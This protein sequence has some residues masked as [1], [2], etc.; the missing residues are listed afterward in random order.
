MNLKNSF[1][2][3]VIT[4]L[5]Y[6]SI[7][8]LMPIDKLQFL[9]YGIL[10]LSVGLIIF[11]IE[12]DVI[13]YLYALSMFFGVAVF[14]RE[15]VS[16]DVSDLLFPLFCCINFPLL[17]QNVTKKYKNI[18]ISLFILIAILTLSIPFNFF[19]HP[20]LFS[21]AMPWYLY[22]AIQ[23]PGVVLILYHFLY[24]KKNRLWV[25]LSLLLVVSMIQIP[26]VFY[27]SIFNHTGNVI[28]AGVHGT[29]RY[30]HSL[31]A[32][33]FFTL[34]PLFIAVAIESKI[35]IHRIMGAVLTVFSFYVIVISGSR[36]VLLGLLVGGGLYV[37]S[38]IR[39]N[40][41]SIAVLLLTPLIGVFLYFFTPLKDIYHHTFQ[42]N[43]MGGIDVSSLS[44]LLIWKETLRTF[45]HSSLIEKCIGIGAGLYRTI[46]YEFVI[47]DGS[48][49]ASGAHNNYLHLLIEV[50]V[51]GLLAFFAHFACLGRFL[52]ALG[53][54]DLASK[55]FF[56]GMIG[57]LM[58][59]ITQETFW[60]QEA[61]GSF[62]VFY[63]T[64]FTVIVVRAEFSEK[65]Y[66]ADVKL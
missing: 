15:S 6:F 49:G 25:L 58:S 60:F 66:L 19:K 42:A 27:Q 51:V 3:T 18:V 48:K 54:K 56:F 52:L 35:I 12:P 8:Y 22:R 29:F 41:K 32:M 63:L 37:L 7:D 5:L 40:R 43:E 39:W 53:K 44:R 20:L 61:F 55:L 26:L 46:K 16:V 50:G 57:F 17:K 31:I 65:N 14:S 33:V 4:L 2:I 59:G 1:L 38:N 34:L 13:T 64:I 9:A 47:W 28:R 45:L 10:G 62:W 30:H 24:E 21:I 23:L 36:S 11:I